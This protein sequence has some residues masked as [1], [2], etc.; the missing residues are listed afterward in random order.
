MTDI[1]DDLDA[2]IDAMRRD[3]TSAFHNRG[4][5]MKEPAFRPEEDRRSHRCG[6]SRF[7]ATI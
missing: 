2:I 6:I 1:I 3:N 5:E 4:N 7:N